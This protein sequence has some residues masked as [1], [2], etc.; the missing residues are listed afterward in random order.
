MEEKKSDKPKGTSGDDKPNGS[1]AAGDRHFESLANWTAVAVVTLLVCI[2][3]TLVLAW[4][5]SEG[6]QP[7]GDRIG[8]CHGCHEQ[9]DRSVCPHHMC[10][11]H[12]RH[13]AEEGRDVT[14]VVN[15]AGGT[16]SQQAPPVTPPPCPE[17]PKPTTAEVK[18]GGQDLIVVVDK[19]KVV[20]HVVD[21]A[22]VV[23]TEKVEKEIV[24]EPPQP[25]PPDCKQLV[26][27]VRFE[28]GQCRVRFQRQE[29]LNIADRLQGQTGTVLVIGHPDR[30]RGHRHAGH[31]AK[32]VGKAL[33]KALKERRGTQLA[34]VTRAASTEGTGAA[35]TETCDEAHF[36]TA[37]VYLIEGLPCR[38]RLPQCRNSGQGVPP[39]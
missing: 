27:R 4:C 12:P 31:R 23:R 38:A 15:V 22:T 1:P 33:R 32:R 37:G 35:G 5:A 10:R 13:P 17:C 6:R 30:E 29:V 26:G 24:V 2:V 34:V 11:H 39:A 28:P 16:V 7:K 20:E 14:L 3:G 9:Q 21:K 36:G 25:P 18:V 19:E 8:Q